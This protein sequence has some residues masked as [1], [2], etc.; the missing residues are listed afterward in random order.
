M[1]Y[2]SGENDAGWLL[3]WVTYRIGSWFERRDQFVP[4]RGGSYAVVV[5]FVW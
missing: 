4:K 5:M 1:L 2:I 3:E